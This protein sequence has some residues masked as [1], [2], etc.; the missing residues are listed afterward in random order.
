ML[1]GLLFLVSCNHDDN[2]TFR[3]PFSLAGNFPIFITC[4]GVVMNLRQE[5][6]VYK[7]IKNRYIAFEMDE[8]PVL[9]TFKG[10]VLESMK[11]E[12]GT[13]IKEIEVTS[14]LK[15]EIGKNCV[16]EKVNY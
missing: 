3:G 8:Q 16:G 11:L 5:E 1:I 12:D 6:E 13:E 2:L 14:F 7:K 10:K 9:L 4:E 15:M